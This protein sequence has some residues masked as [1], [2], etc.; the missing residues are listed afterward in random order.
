MSINYLGIQETSLIGGT[1]TSSATATPVTG[2]VAGDLLIMYAVITYNSG[3]FPTLT[4]P[5]GWTTAAE[6]ETNTSYTPTYMVAYKI[7]TGDDDYTLS[8]TA[9]TGR[10]NIYVM[11]FSGDYNLANLI[12][13]GVKYGNNASSFLIPSVTAVADNSML[14]SFCVT[15]GGVISADD[16]ATPPSGMTLLKSSNVADAN[17]QMAVAYQN[18]IPTG[19]T[20]VKTWTAFVPSNQYGAGVN[21]I[22]NGLAI[23]ID[24]I[25]GDSSNPD[26]DVT[27]SNTA[28]TTGLGTITATTFTDSSGFVSTATPTM[29]SGDGSFVFV[30]PWADGTQQAKFGSVTASVTD[31]TLTATLP[32]NLALPS[33]YSSTTWSGATD[34][35]E[36]YLG[37]Y[38]AL[39]NDNRVYYPTVVDG[40]TV[41][42]NADGWMSFS[43]LPVTVPLLLHDC[44]TGG[45][46]L[47]T[48]K[49]LV[50]TAGG[51]VIITS[52]SKN[53]Y[54]GLGLGIGF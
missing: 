45:T 5:S 35:G 54:I 19:A 7:A 37:H 29:P 34:L 13:S 1:S 32:A 20:G 4:P 41:T 39:T 46:G 16:S 22:I 52:N 6:E 31:G 30:W 47:I 18:A 36:F 24:T 15:K 44:R 2:T 17:N 21:I 33:T 3:L 50:V 25:N 28:T 51:A 10:R 49:T 8:Y 9:T 23:T 11:R 42:I 40:C 38:L 53:H 27:A 43:S 12:T 14:L 26:I 48:T